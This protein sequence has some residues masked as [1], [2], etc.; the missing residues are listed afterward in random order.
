MKAASHSAQ[1]VAATREKAP[2]T[3]MF[4]RMLLRAAVLRRGRAAAALIAMLVAAT[5]ATAMLNLYVD[6]QAKLRR[7]FRNYGAN[8]IVVGRDGASLPPNALARVDSVL[9]GRGV[10]APFGLIVARTGSGQP[11]VVAGTAFERVR[12]LDRWWSVSNWPSTVPTLRQSQGRPSGA[13]S[14][15]EMEH[16]SL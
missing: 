9:A 7:E 12:Q 3:S 6:V 13:E 2:H 4:M 16:P 5:V 11:I 1:G 14:A 10:A 8:I 15:G